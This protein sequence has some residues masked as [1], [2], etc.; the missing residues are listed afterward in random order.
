V[1]ESNPD[2][3]SFVAEVYPM[4]YGFEVKDGKLLFNHYSWQDPIGQNVAFDS[5]THAPSYITRNYALSP[6]RGKAKKVGDNRV[7]L[8]GA[9]KMAPPV[10]T[11]ICHYGPSP[12]HNRLAQ[13][14]HASNSSDIVIENVTVYAAGGM[15]LIAERCDNIRLDKFV[16]TSTDERT[17]STRADATHFLGCKGVVQLENCLLEHMADDGINVHGAYIRIEEY[18]GDNKFLCAISH[19]QQKGLIF[20]EPGDKVMITSRETVLP[21]F[22]TTVKG[23]HILDEEFLEVI[24]ADIPE[25]MP[26]GRL[27]IENLTWYP[28]VIMRNNIIRDN[29]ARSALISTKGNVL[30]E[31]NVFSSQMHGILI[32]GDNK[33]WYESGGVRDVTIN[34]NVFENI[35]YGSGEGYPLYASPMFTD[36]QRLGDDQYHWNVRFTGN[37]IKSFNG[38][39]CHAKSVKGLV[40]SG[41]TVE[42]SSDYPGGLELPSIDLDY[43]KDA[44]IENNE[45]IGFDKPQRIE[46]KENCTNVTIAKNKGLE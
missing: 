13:A 37:K 42:L 6:N 28:D 9:T 14:I 46:Q 39:L 41:N 36:D 30:I 19:G 45:F 2:K 27:S 3:N 17:M 4:K 16:V 5:A 1:V 43:C 33:S 32:E 44:V 23:V 29:R 38:L 7:E 21:L 20:C 18:K 35:G 15:A 10:G 31:N 8:T 22:E 40:L 25:P 11:V 24:V 26:K 12:G 34:K